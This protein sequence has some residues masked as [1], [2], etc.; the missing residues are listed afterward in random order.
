MAGLL[1]LAVPVTLFPGADSAMPAPSLN[2]LLEFT[3][4]LVLLACELWLML[5]VI[6]YGLQQLD[7]SRGTMWGATLLGACLAAGIAE[8]SNGRGHILVEQ[9]VA[10]STAS[11]HV[12]SG[13]CAL[14]MALLFFA[15]LQRSRAR[16]HAAERLASAQSEQ[17]LMRSRLVQ[18]RLQA[19]QAR[20]DPQ[21]LFGLLEEVQCAYEHDP[22]R[23]EQ[24]LDELVAFLR[25]ALPRL[26]SASSTVERELSLA[27]SFAQLR[28]VAGA[29]EIDT[30]LEIDDDVARS[31]FPP[32]VL[33]PLVDEA[34]R[35][36]AGRCEFSAR[37][38]A[39]VCE[40]VLGLPATP[41]DGTV[42]RVRALLADTHGSYSDVSVALSSNGFA[43]AS[44]KVPYEPA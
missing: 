24:L 23:A 40:V 42:A 43:T 20:I 14:V 3:A 30:S 31:R 28:K 27:C 26:R 5:L 11:M 25:L 18:A 8:I 39:E 6:G 36:H 44:L 34:L 19:V 15:H 7:D 38:D 17:R 2:D 35:I 1:S 4:W 9:G 37:R 33:L 29:N 21:L 10:Q 41:M 16:E 12:Y 13:A 32:G 22:I